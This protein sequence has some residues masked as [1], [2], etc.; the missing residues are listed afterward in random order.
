MLS[1]VAWT[2]AADHAVGRWQQARPRVPHTR[3]MGLGSVRGRAQPLSREGPWSFH[4]A[5]IGG[6]G[7]QPAATCTVQERW[8]GLVVPF[9]T[10]PTMA[11][12]Q[13]RRGKDGQAERQA[14]SSRSW[15]KGDGQETYKFGGVC[16][17]GTAFTMWGQAV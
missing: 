15:R 6:G 13:L 3:V 16:C 9:H 14:L 4:A 8:P 12:D 1:T 2:V 17:L 5:G 11:W 10:P 7:L